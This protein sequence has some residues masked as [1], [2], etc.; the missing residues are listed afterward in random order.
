MIGD[1]Q[2]KAIAALRS[3]G[4]PLEQSF[5]DP[6]TQFSLAVKR[7]VALGLETQ[8]KRWILDIGSQVPYFACAVDL[9]G[10]DA[11]SVDQPDPLIAEAGKILGYDFISHVFSPRDPLPR[12]PHR[13]DLITCFAVDRIIGNEGFKEAAAIVDTMIRSLNPAGHVILSPPRAWLRGR[14]QLVSRWRRT[15]RARVRIV[16][17]GEWIDFELK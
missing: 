5:R 15:L 4:H 7:A 13:F 6:R 12:L 3:K 8:P 17:C 9:F 11:L 1:V 16:N 10:H 2:F 14:W